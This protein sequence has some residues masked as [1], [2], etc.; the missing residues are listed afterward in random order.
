MGSGSSGSSGTPSSF[1]FG[2]S[3]ARA[4]SMALVPAALEDL[5]L[6]E[7]LFL[8]AT[9]HHLL[10]VAP[11]PLVPPHLPSVPLGESEIYRF[12][13]FGKKLV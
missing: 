12:F 6:Q 10:Q 2:I 3:G 4:L 5:D 11:H 7:T 13:I 9:E 1:G 8:A